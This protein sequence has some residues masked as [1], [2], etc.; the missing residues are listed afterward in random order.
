MMRIVP[1]MESG[2]LRGKGLELLDDGT[3]S[4]LCRYYPEAI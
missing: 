2:A 3:I 1:N 4:H